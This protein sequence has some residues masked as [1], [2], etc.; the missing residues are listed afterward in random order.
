MAGLSLCA[1]T[2][3]GESRIAIDPIAGV[4][5]DGAG[6]GGVT[7]TA[8]MTTIRECRLAAA[9][10]G[11]DGLDADLLLGHVLG[12]G[13]GWLFAHAHDDL[14]AKAEAGFAAL[15]ERRRAGE[16]IAYL[17]GHWG[18]WS[19]DLEV[20]T[21]T[22]IPRV[23]TELLVELALRHLPAPGNP[24]HLADLGTGSGAVALALAS[25]RPDVQVTAL[26]LSAEALA[27]A[28]RNVRRLRLDN[29]DLVRGNWL[30]ALSPGRFKVIV[31]NPPYVESGDPHLRRGDLRFEPLAALAAGADGLDAIRSI[32][33]AAHACLEPDG[34]LLFEHGM[35]Q[36]SASRSLLTGA[37]YAEV[38]TMQDLEQR[39]RVSMGRKPA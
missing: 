4:V 21:A 34:W 33:G 1:C 19:L 17:L 28:R 11:I 20:S 5:L 35:A 7:Y 14:D 6:D 13:R 15:I 39:D 36:G 32:V 29:V 2:R 12:R 22:L 38:A 9:A 31:A 3:H 25:E 18:F 24:I 16:P 27:V 26:D 8:G 23:E 37:G 30:A 10:R